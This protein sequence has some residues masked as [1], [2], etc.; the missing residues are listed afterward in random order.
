M[1]LNIAQ[2]QSGIPSAFQQALGG[3]QM[4]LQNRQM[5]EEAAL[6][7]QQMQAQVDRQK[8]IAGILGGLSTM[9]NPTASDYAKAI[10]AVPELREGLSEAWGMMDADRQKAVQS[11]AV[12]LYSALSSGNADIAKQMLE[13]RIEAAENAGDARSAAGAKAM[14]QMM[15][16]NPQAAKTSAG[17]MLANSMGEKEFADVLGKLQPTEKGTSKQQDY[18][19]YRAQ[20]QE[21]GRTPLS[22]NEWDKQGRAA[23]ATTVNVG[24]S[25]VG[26]IPQGYELITDPQTGS[27]RMQ[28]L[29]GGPAE[30]EIAG[31]EIKQEE[32]ARSAVASIDNVID[33]VNEAIGIT[34]RGTAGYAALFDFLP[35]SGSRELANTVDTIQANLGFDKLQ[36]MRD[37]SPTGGA[38]GQVSEREL[39]FL[40]GALANLDRRQ[41]PETLKKNLR[42]ILTHY[43]NWRD[44]VI[45]SR[46]QELMSQGMT[47]EEALQQLATEFPQ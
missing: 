18:M 27:R 2:L 13:E 4:G 5:Q 23:G 8:Q 19:F 21:S 26:T 40:Q 39:N 46:G 11:D 22:F 44:A 36:S 17:L 34:G 32:K 20:E 14:L 47:E 42:K 43:N 45:E 31:Q 41:K 16:V 9:Q 28:P 7:Q 12:Q 25:E 35:E 24:Q 3:Y 1:A 30:R 33:T 38:L 6:K 29:A 37:A 10:T 15:E